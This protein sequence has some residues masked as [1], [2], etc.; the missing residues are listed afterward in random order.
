MQ[1]VAEWKCR[2]MTEKREKESEKERER[3]ERYY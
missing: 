2:K 3:E 1:L